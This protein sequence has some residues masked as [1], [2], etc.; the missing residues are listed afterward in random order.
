MA[1]DSRLRI[2]QTHGEDA[3][4]ALEPDKILQPLRK[5]RKLLK[6]I[7]NPPTPEEVHDVR[8]AA[9]KM[10]ASFQALSLD[11]YGNERRVLKHVVRL[12]KR[13][14]KVRDMDVLTS[15][16]SKVHPD[17]EEDCSVQLLEHLGARRKKYAKKLQAAIRQYGPVVRQRLKRAQSTIDKILRRGAKAASNGKAAS[18]GVVAS[19]FNLS[20][21]LASPT[22]L[23]RA[24]L[25]PYRLKV[26]ELR[27]LLQMGGNTPQ[28]DLIDQLGEVKDAIGEWHDWEELLSFATDVLDHVPGCRLVSELKNISH[29]KYERA[30]TA[31]DS[32]RSKFFRAPKGKSSRGSSAVMQRP[33]QPVLSATASLA[34]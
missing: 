28:P 34:A 18:A 12:R 30:L 29:E 8:T 13:A 1:N 2:I 21:E 25:H 24:N 3:T 23:G 19:V 20:S 6:Q 9:R 4:M 22:R 10:E 14:G 16:A 11:S 27:S 17:G 7:S 32:M 15:Y 31:T 5:T 26:K 33:S